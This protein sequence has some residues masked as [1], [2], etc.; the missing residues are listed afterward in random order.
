MPK[1]TELKCHQSS[2]L[3]LLLP[4]NHPP[5]SGAHYPWNRLFYSIT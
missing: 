1:A 5:S 2:V 3:S 4:P